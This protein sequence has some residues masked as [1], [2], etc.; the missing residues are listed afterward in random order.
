MANTAAAAR[1]DTPIF[2]VGV[3]NVAVGRLDR[4]P[5]LAGYLLGLTAAGE[6]ADH[7]GFALAEPCRS[8]D[9]WDNVAHGV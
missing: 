7:F 4:D 2:P 5:Q 6:Q 8:F 9:A 3:L 1:V